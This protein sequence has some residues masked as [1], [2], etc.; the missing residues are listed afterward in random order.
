[1]QEDI[2]IVCRET[3]FNTDE[4]VV[5]NIG[6]LIKDDLSIQYFQLRQRY[7]PELEYYAILKSNL[8]IKDYIVSLIEK[9]VSSILYTYV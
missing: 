9:K 5:Y 8:G 3:N 4:F 1:M 7:N 6:Y 2:L